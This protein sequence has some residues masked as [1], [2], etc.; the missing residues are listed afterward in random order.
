[1]TKPE[2]YKRHSAKSATCAYI[3]SIPSDNG[4]ISIKLRPI[5]LCVVA[6]SM[7]LYTLYDRSST[8]LAERCH[9]KKYVSRFTHYIEIQEAALWHKPNFFLYCIS[10]KQLRIQSYRISAWIGHSFCL[11]NKLIEYHLFDKLETD[12]DRKRWYINRSHE[13]VIQTSIVVFR[14]ISRANYSINNR[15]KSVH[16]SSHT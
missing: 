4:I 3:L 15:R 14:L 13:N 11:K 9:H 10:L 6:P 12:L 5:I 2:K 7:K 8:L 1:M 16:N